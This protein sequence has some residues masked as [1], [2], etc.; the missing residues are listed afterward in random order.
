MGSCHIV[1][2]QRFPAST[3]SWN[4]NS[5]FGWAVANVGAWTL[6]LQNAQNLL[7]TNK[8][9]MNHGAKSL[10]KC[11][12]QGTVCARYLYIT[13][14]L[15][16]CS[17]TPDRLLGTLWFLECAIPTTHG[18][19]GRWYRCMVA[20][21]SLI[22]TKGGW[23]PLFVLIESQIFCPNYTPTRDHWRRGMEI[24]LCSRHCL[25]AMGIS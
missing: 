21:Y 1:C 11:S 18:V 3:V 4:T 15:W 12:H 10:C 25:H 23:R 16:K 19:E 22:I 20:A 8:F 6:D 13:P 24:M 9:W 14:S 17:W 2:W 7:S 5:V